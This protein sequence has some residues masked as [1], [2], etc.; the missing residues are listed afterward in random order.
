MSNFQNERRV[1]VHLER[2][3]AEMSHVRPLPAPLPYLPRV[4]KSDGL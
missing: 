4:S 3:L 2:R 1:R